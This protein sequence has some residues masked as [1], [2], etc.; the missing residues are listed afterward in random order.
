MSVDVKFITS[1]S[2]LPEHITA[3]LR[4]LG[5]VTDSVIPLRPLPEDPPHFWITYKDGEENRKGFLATFKDCP[6]EPLNTKKEWSVFYVVARDSGLK[7]CQALAEHFG[8][9]LMDERDP[10][11][12]YKKIRKTPS[13]NVSDLLS[14]EEVLSLRLQSVF[15]ESE[16]ETASKLT[17]LIIKDP[18]KLSLIKDAVATYQEESKRDLD[19]VTGMKP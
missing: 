15:G 5:H 18:E 13:K 3:V 4:N 1:G 6:E 19:K 11:V 12:G 2:L 10:N 16:Y 17:S 7:I 8:G 14:P 9:Y